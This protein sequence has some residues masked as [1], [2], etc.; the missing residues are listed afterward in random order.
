MTA[1]LLPL[2]AL[3][4]SALAVPLIIASRRRPPLRETWSVVAA[5]VQTVLVALM[6]PPALAGAPLAWVGPPLVPGVRLSLRA[7]PLAVLFGLVA[8]VLWI[9][10]TVYSIGYTRALGERHQT[11]YF[12]AFA[13]C[14]LATL[15]LALAGDL[16]TFFLFFE[17]LTVAAYPLVVHAGTAEARR[18]GRVYLAYTLAGGSALLAAVA[19][20]AAVAGRVDFVPGGLLRPDAAGPGTLAGLL[21]LFVVGCGVKAALVPLHTWLPVAMV[22]PTPVSAL[23][24]AVA[25][26][27]AGVFG[28]AR[29]VGFVF[30]PATLETLG[31]ASA[32]ATLALVT[33]A[34]GSLAALAEDNLKRRLAFSTVS[35]LAY[36]VLGVAVGPPA[37]FAGGLLHLGAHALLKIT[38]FFCAGALHVAAHVERVSEMDGIGRRMPVTMGAFALVAFLLAGLPPGAA[39][40]SKWALLIGAADAGAW[41]AVAVLLAS[42]LL[43]VAYLSWPV[44]RAF[45]SPPSHEA[46]EA[47]ATMLVPLVV[48]AAVGLLVGLAPAGW[49]PLLPLAARVA[50]AVTPR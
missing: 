16:F 31:A 39:F 24:H 5:L 15:G 25:V 14:L 9:L 29:V 19:G 42:G 2:L 7:D 22:A 40:V 1:S 30:G 41:A 37:A 44:V 47:P 4:P 45:R 11:R 38:L 46:G 33:I 27:K 8:S 26:V 18:A 20:T 43:N 50:D 13:L 17:L 28:L 3:G 48:T 32:L 35:H 49:L 12:A 23:L 36:V 10:T 21:A 34:F 6:V